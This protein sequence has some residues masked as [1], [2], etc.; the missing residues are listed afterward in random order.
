MKTTVLLSCILSC[1]VLSGCASDFNIFDLPNTQEAKEN[2]AQLTNDG[3]GNFNGTCY[4]YNTDTPWS[5]R[6]EAALGVVFKRDNGCADGSAQG[7]T[8]DIAAGELRSGNITIEE[9]AL[10]TESE[11]EREESLERSQFT[12]SVE[13]AVEASIIDWLSLEMQSSS[14]ILMTSILKYDGMIVDDDQ[15]YTEID[16]YLSQ[17]GDPSQELRFVESSKQYAIK[18]QE[19]YLV[20]GEKPNF[21]PGEDEG[22]IRAFNGMYYQDSLLELNRNILNVCLK[23][24]SQ[25]G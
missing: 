8:W 6:P 10:E 21:A 12:I 18:I 24:I 14:V 19:F 1:S 13:D 20:G 5:N 3:L 15:L 16:R 25:D 17:H 9:L 23:P 4:S 2:F 22:E 7:C 11:E